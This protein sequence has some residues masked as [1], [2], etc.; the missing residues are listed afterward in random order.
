MRKI[1]IIFILL[2]FV[3]VF[4][5]SQEISKVEDSKKIDNPLSVKRISF[6]GLVKAPEDVLRSIVQ[7]K[8]GQEIDPDQLSKDIKNLYKDTGLFSDIF[9]DVETAEGGG[10]NVIFNVKESPKIEG[11]INIIGN[12]KIKFG[13]I[14]KAITLRSGEIYNQRLSWRSEQAILQLYKEEG[15]YLASVK[16]YTDPGSEADVVSVT[17]E[18]SEGERIKIQ[19]INLDGNE[20]ISSEKLRKRMKTRVDKRFDEAI[21]EEDLSR[22]LTFYQDSGY[23]QAKLVKHEKSFTE[24]EIG[25]IIDIEIDEGPQYIIN[26]YDIKVGYSEKPAFKQ[27]KIQSMLNPAEGEIFDRG[28]FEKTILGIKQLY[29]EEGYVLMTLNPIPSYNESEGFVDFLIEIDEGSVI[30][31]DQIKINGLVK[32]KKKVIRRE[33]DQLK[34]KT[35]EFLDMKA[36]RKARQR[37]FQMGFLRNV[38]F[39][40]SNTEGQRRNLNVNL[41]ESPRTGMFS[42]GGGYGSEGGLFGIAEVGENNLMGQAYNIHLKG[43]VGTWYRRTAELR[44]GTPWILGSPTRANMRIYNNTSTRR[45]YRGLTSYSTDL[46]DISYQHVR[47]IDSRKGVSLTLGRPIFEDIDASIRFRN[48]DANVK[49]RKTTQGGGVELENY[50]DRFTR[51]LTLML[52]RDTRDYRTSLYHPISGAYGTISYEYSGGF[53]GADNNFRKYSLDFSWFIKTW[54]NFVFAS[55]LSGGML[56]S[57]ASAKSSGSY[58]DSYRIDPLY[59]ERFWIGGIDTVRG[60]E[61]FEIVPTEGPRGYNPNGGNKQIYANFEYRVPVSPQLTGVLFF[62]V[63][64]VWQQ[65]L[66]NL[67]RSDLNFKKGVGVGIRFDL[68]GGMLVR[69]EYGFPLDRDP[70]VNDRS[71]K[72]H[73]SVGPGF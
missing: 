42:L 1:K 31:I 65:S 5:H 11:R 55:H 6:Q 66:S 22:I 69:L 26:E 46:T 38:E 14:K 15:Y 61:D 25:I 20:G 12:E 9:V 64:D 49:H 18:V 35:G 57:R 44:L 50:L 56:D 3:G 59:F 37:L 2:L 30:V 17:F 72:F 47:Y 54:Q 13:K 62:D 23:A 7:T 68:G 21:F 41:D 71:G 70:R 24:D 27:E 32:T 10:L 16:V 19:K 29:N 52:S 48:E 36:L 73:F 39:V 53:L 60:Y 34:I 63:G 33:L 8:I 67:S 51:S 58:Y 4:G 28:E 40:P 43:E 45:Y